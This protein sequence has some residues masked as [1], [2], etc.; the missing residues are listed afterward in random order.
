M[1]DVLAIT[2]PIYIII[3]LGFLMTR[4]GV[5]SKADMRIFGKF[6]L[7]LALPALLFRSLSQRQIGDVLNLSYLLA[8]LTGSLLVISSG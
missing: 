7:N 2:S 3:A 4:S 8:Y 6:V 1:L 5:F